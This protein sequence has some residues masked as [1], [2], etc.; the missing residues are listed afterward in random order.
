[1]INLIGVLSKLISWSTLVLLYSIHQA[2]LQNCYSK[3]DVVDLRLK[4][5]K[6]RRRCPEVITA[7]VFSAVYLSGC[8]GRKNMDLGD[9]LR[10]AMIA[11]V[12]ETTRGKKQRTVGSIGRSSIIFGT[13]G[14]DGKSE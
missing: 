10:M 13:D 12:V 11:S 5:A 4:F 2:A 3:C 7:I 6:M 14:P 1:M 9:Y 8:L